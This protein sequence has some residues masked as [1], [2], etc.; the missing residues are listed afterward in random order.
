MRRRT[1][2]CAKRRI[3]R[4]QC[5]A[6]ARGSARGRRAAE[7]PSGARRIV[8]GQ[9]TAIEMLQHSG[10]RRA[11]SPKSGFRF[12]GAPPREVPRLRSLRI[13]PAWTDVAINRNPR[14]KLLA[15]GRDKKG[16]W[17][18]VYSQAAGR[19]REQRKYE[20]L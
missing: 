2:G 5:P 6:P 1:F 19:D 10:F 20:K 9:M 8:A 16:R 7:H 11:G 12:V 13:P 17:Q 18:Y 3:R 14:A 15:V 4:G